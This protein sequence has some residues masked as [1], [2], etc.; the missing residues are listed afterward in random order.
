M[1]QPSIG[2]LIALMIGATVVLLLSIDTALACRFFHRRSSYVVC[3][4]VV[5]CPPVMSCPTPCATVY[6]GTSDCGTCS[7]VY[8]G[9][10]YDSGCVD[11]CVSGCEGGEVIVD[12]TYEPA[13]TVVQPEEPTPALVPDVDSNDSLSEIPAD[14]DAEIAPAP[15]A[16]AFDALPNDTD[17]V[18]PAIVEEPV[19]LDEPAADEPVDDFFAEPATDA[20][21]DAEPDAA[22]PD[23]FFS[24]PTGRSARGRANRRDAG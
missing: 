5:T 22:A 8:G 7:T 13:A 14:D 12:S 19:D 24:D 17:V 21:A 18:E 3:S 15:Q 20:P 1:R 6:G 23:D 2:R 9:P 16:D 4:P 10:I 11:G